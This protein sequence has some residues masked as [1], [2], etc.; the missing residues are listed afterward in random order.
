MA[1]KSLLSATVCQALCGHTAGGVPT[2]RTAGNGGVAQQR[3]RVCNLLGGL[4]FLCVPGSWGT[5]LVLR[6]AARCW[7]FYPRGLVCEKATAACQS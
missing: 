6:K 2:C 1:T 3:G 4:P 7:C 5:V